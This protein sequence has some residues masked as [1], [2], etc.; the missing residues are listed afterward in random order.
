MKKLFCAAGAA[1]CVA[2]APAS[3]NET[4]AFCVD[5]ASSNGWDTSP[6]SCVGDVA[7]ANPDV[8]ATVLALTSPEDVEAMDQS[9]KDKLSVCFPQ[10]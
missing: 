4:E 1:V 10:E 8:K 6:C 3:A 2:F 9:V 7:D 5:F